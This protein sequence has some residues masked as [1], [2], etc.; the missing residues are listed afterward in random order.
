MS[1]NNTTETSN[2]SSDFSFGL[3]CP[4]A[5]L[6]QI[7]LEETKFDFF[8]IGFTCL[9][10]PPIVV[11]NVL[12]ILAV[13]SRTR[14]QTPSN[15]LLASLA[16][17]DLLVGVLVQP[18][19]FLEAILFLNKQIGE[20]C[21]VSVVNLLQLSIL[22]EASVRILTFIAWERYV[23]TTNCSC[24]L[25]APVCLLFLC[26]H[27]TSLSTVPVSLL[28]LFAY[29]SCVITSRENNCSCCLGVVCSTSSSLRGRFG[30]CRL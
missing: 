12:V 2:S 30:R 15:I 1:N 28:L 21:T 4:S 16:V 5:H 27:S 24:V 23:A 20:M 17:T 14:L 8:M 13:K 7:N 19:S 22:F 11:L 3:H 6:F 29:C 25:T 26:A 18:L 9:T 10:S